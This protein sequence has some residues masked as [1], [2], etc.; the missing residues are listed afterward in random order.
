MLLGLRVGF[1]SCDENCL[2]GGAGR[3]YIDIRSMIYLV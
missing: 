3:V 1:E 2:G